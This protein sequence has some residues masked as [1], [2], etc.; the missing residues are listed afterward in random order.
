MQAGADRD[1]IHQHQDRLAE[2]DIEQRLGRRKLENPA[3]LK[4][5]CEAF[6]AQLEE[7][8]AQ[9]S[10]AGVIAASEQGIPARALGQCEQARGHLIYRILLHYCPAR[11]AEGL[12]HSSV[13][14]AQ[15]VV[16]LGRGGDGGTRVAARVLLPDGHRGR[17][18]I[19][20][21][22]RRLF[23]ALQKLA[24]VGRHRFHITPLAFRID[25]VECQRRLARARDAGHHGQL[26]VGNRNRNVLQIMGSRA[27]NPDV[28]LHGS[29]GYFLSIARA[30]VRH[31]SACQSWVREAKPAS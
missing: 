8:V 17:D 9:R 10:G 12:A 5:P 7:V 4:Q 28:V 29:D 14:Q 31:A 20:V 24:G 21:V 16:A 26:V 2:I 22:Y 15:K 13:E 3:R 11:W 6:L 19:D 27:A 23:H 18:A 25:G 30:Q 1:A